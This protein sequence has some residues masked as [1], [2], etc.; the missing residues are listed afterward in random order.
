V[1]WDTTKVVKTTKVIEDNVNPLYFETIELAYESNSQDDLPPFI[2]DVY[3]KDFN[4][5]DSDDFICRSI[6]YKYEAEITE[7]DEVKRPKWH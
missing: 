6:I 4:P 1:F 7:D 3:D 2:L 5:L